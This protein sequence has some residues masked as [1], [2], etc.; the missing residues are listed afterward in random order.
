MPTKVGPRAKDC[1]T[2]AELKAKSPTLEDG[3]YTVFPNGE[4]NAGARTHCITDNGRYYQAVWQ[5]FGGPDYG[6][7]G[8]GQVANATLQSSPASYDGEVGPYSALGSMGSKINY[9]LHEYWKNKTG[10]RWLRDLRVYNST[11]NSIASDYTIELVYDSNVAW[12][13]SW[14]TVDDTGRWYQLPGYI[15]M[16][17][18]GTRQGRTRIMNGFDYNQN[19]GLAQANSGDDPANGEE[20]ISGSYGRHAISYLYNSTGYNA[21]RC[22]PTCWNGSE[23]QAEENIWYVAYDD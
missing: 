4:T 16:Y 13:D 19:V 7:Y 20:V 9:I 12:T 18:D 22:N 1:K 21:I 15:E 23:T 10:V 11:N 14:T 6:D 3:M 2:F 5:Q 8:T 17:Y